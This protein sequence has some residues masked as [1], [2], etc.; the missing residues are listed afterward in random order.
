MGRPANVVD[1]GYSH[2]DVPLRR[3]IGRF[4]LDAGLDRP[5][6]GADLDR[7]RCSTRCAGSLMLG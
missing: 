4:R 7:P 3:A 2:T 5:M 1:N 6:P